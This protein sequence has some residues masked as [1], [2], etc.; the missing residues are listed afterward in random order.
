MSISSQ[1][2]HPAETQGLPSGEELL[3]SLHSLIP[4]GTAEEE[5]GEP[6]N[7][8]GVDDMFT[9]DFDRLFLFSIVNNFAALENIP[10]KA[11]ITFTSQQSHMISR[12]L[13]YLKSTTTIFSQALAEKLFKA[14]IEARDPKVI[15]LLLKT[16]LVDPNAIVCFDDNNCR[17]T[18][19][20]RSATLRHVEIT[21]CLLSAGT[22]VNKTYVGE[23]SHLERGA[24]ECAI[25][26]W[27]QYSP[28]DLGFVKLLLDH[29]AVVYGDLAGAAIRWGDQKLI[30]ELM[31]RF[32]P[33]HHPYCFSNE[34]LTDAVEFLHNDLSFKI[35][36]QAVKACQDT[37]YNQCID[38]KPERCRS[39]MVQAAQR[40]NLEVVKLLVTYGDQEG[41]DH[42]LVA[43]I[44]SRSRTLIDFL[45]DKGADI[46]GQACMIDQP[47]GFLTTPL[48]EAIR[49]GDDEL[50]AL[51]ENGGA[52]SQIEERGRFEA[53]M[54][55]VSEIGNATF[56]HKLLQMV[57]KP[58][59]K[60]L[61]DPLNAAIENKNEDVA[62]RLLASGAYVNDGRSGSPLLKALEI[63]SKPIVSAILEC[64]VELNHG[65]LAIAAE[66]GDLSIIEDLF[67]MGANINA[68][69]SAAALAVAVQRRNMPLVKLLVKLGA[70]LNLCSGGNKSP[71]S[72]A[73]STQDS[74]IINHL[75][76][77][78][79]DPANGRAII[80]AMIQ[81]GETLNF[82][83]RRFCERYPRGRKGFG[84]DVL[85]YVLQI[86]SDPL[87]DLCLG[88]KFDVN[89]LVESKEYCDMNALGLV[90]RKYQGKRLDLVNKILDAGG[91][92][93]GPASRQGKRSSPMIFQN[94]S[95]IIQ[96]A[97]LEAIQTK[98]VPLVD[99][100]IHRGADVQKEAKLGLKRTPLQKACEVGS[101]SIVD[102]LLRHHANVRAPPAV[103]GGGDALQLAAKS[104]SVRIANRLLNCG[105][106]VNAPTSQVGGHSALGYAAKYG[107][108]D[109]IKVLWNA[110]GTVFTAEQYD[111]AILLAQ[112]NGHFACV[113]LLQSLSSTSP[114]FIDFGV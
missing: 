52:L 23:G 90:I 61:A 49:S 89:S 62:L 21:K 18:P 84:G 91:D 66:W 73:V 71:L 35:I 37:H 98:S 15:Q 25:R 34:M 99:L 81:D 97:F 75:I 20:E 8:I 6:L 100:L 17:R 113:S 87:L 2:G 19:I 67:F 95:W 88:A 68:S 58:D 45:L 69:N 47:F 36:Q 70:D 111:S 30:V 3:E 82:L 79:A 80:N 41:L 59:G 31:S 53:A 14:A 85:Q 65:N 96:T 11:I 22:D 5:L 106:D 104:G 32:D 46:N 101:Y 44:R 110:S 94:D 105:V 56:L 77:H 93:N 102:L 40:G 109:M 112:E 27:G 38:S 72:A 28:I 74:S 48:A 12:I 92:I 43:A 29:G 114:A 50:I 103:R 54:L 13:Y 57:P 51:F 26:K 55:A 63:R 1:R 9:S 24:L 64:D 7:V 107:R 83:F 76:E 42:A 4:I 60:L 86:P 16:G 10:I 39:L 78:G 33:S 108:V